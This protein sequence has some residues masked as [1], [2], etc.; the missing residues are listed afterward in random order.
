MRIRTLGYAL[1][2]LLAREAL[3]GYDL[4][5][6]MKRPIGFFWHAR[7]SQIY[8]ELAAL[9]AAE[10]VTHEVVAQQDRPDKKL[11]QL[12]AAGREALRR[13]VS[14]PA[15]LPPDRDEL[16]LKTFSIWLADPERGASIY[17][18]REREHDEHLAAYERIRVEMER[19]RGAELER[20]DSPAFASYTTLRRGIEYERGYA[21]WCRWMAETL[22]RAAA[23]Q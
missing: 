1:L 12:T 20:V 2:G 4:A 18:R 9:E 11:Y 5:R 3:S 19:A 23:K 22:E 8:P 10:L 14:E 15:P 7:H 16:M 17:R 13:W 21:A 6:Y